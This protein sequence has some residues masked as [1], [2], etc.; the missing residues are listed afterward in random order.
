MLKKYLISMV[1]LVGLVFPSFSGADFQAPL[2]VKDK[3]IDN[4]EISLSKIDNNGVD[5]VPMLTFI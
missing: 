3:Y 5:P 2:K 4:N 1:L